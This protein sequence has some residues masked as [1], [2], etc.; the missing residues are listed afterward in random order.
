MSR[1]NVAIQTVESLF[2]SQRDQLITKDGLQWISN[3]GNKSYLAV[4]KL[5]NS[6]YLQMQLNQF[7]CCLSVV[8]KV[9][10]SQSREIG[11]QLKDL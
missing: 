10:M 4:P 3:D 2:V 11:F 8:T 1:S 5:S 7:V 6:I 9:K